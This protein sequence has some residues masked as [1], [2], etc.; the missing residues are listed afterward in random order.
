MRVDKLIS[1]MKIDTR[2]NVAR[3]AKKG[4]LIING[5][6]I[7]DKSY[8]VDVENDVVT[9][10]DIP[11]EYIKELHLMLNKDDKTVSAL[12]DSKEKCIAD[13]LDDY[14]RLFNLSVCGRLDKDST[15]LVILTT[16]GKLVHD[17]I[18]PSKEIVKTYEV[19]TRDPIDEKLTR[20]FKN[21]IYL[22]E[23]DYTTKP[24]EIEIIE[25][26]KAIVRISEGKFHQIK[27]M[28]SNLGNEV[29]KLKRTKIGGL[30]LDENLKEGEYRRL[31]EKEIKKIFK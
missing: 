4:F 27:Y 2:K 1:H 26:K 18:S 23:L 31:S 9:Y 6:V 28:F 11:V 22:K 13:L 25:T 24:S 20:F 30:S 8:D 14:Y 16:D 21:G 5:H 10:M 15:G 19:I 29:V 17:I 3:N 7:T 12:K